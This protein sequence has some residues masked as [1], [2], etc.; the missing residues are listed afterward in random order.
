MKKLRESEKRDIVS[1]DEETGMSRSTVMK[2]A[3]RG[4]RKKCK[5]QEKK[6]IRGQKS[7]IRSRA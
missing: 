4:R 2:I 3:I 6:E 1:S 5:K 7:E